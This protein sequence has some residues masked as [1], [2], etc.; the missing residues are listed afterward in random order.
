MS[1]VSFYARSTWMLRIGLLVMVVIAIGAAGSSLEGQRRG[2]QSERL[3]DYRAVINQVQVAL[4]EME[5]VQRGY[6]ITGEEPYLAPYEGERQALAAA[7]KDL[8]RFDDV[9]MRLTVQKQPIAGLIA[10]KV[11][12]LDQTVQLRRDFGPAPAVRL[13]E[14]DVGRRIMTVLHD[15]LNETRRQVDSLVAAQEARS[16][17]QAYVTVGLVSAGLLLSG[18]L[19][20]TSVGFLRQEIGA[21][22]KVEGALRER[23]AALARSNAELEQFAHVASHDL[24]EP[25]RMVSSYTQLLRLRYVGKLGADA[26]EFI[27][28]AVDGTKRMQALINDLLN[29]SRVGSGANP[30]E[31]VNLGVAL[32]DTLK[33]LEMRIKDCGAIVTHDPLPTV[34]ADPVQMRQLL[35][36]LIGN[37][38][39]F[40]SPERT[41]TVD[42]S[43][44]REGP[45]WLI[46]V[47]DNGIGIEGQYFKNV[48]QIFKRLHN[49]ESYPGT[50]IG[51]AVCQKIVERHG[52]RIWIESAFGQGS[53]FLFTLPAMETQS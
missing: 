18:V 24:Q 10:E 17:L 53:T 6:L 36:N 29:L 9:P 51:L 12:E 50:G 32:D 23:E 38:M 48:F 19:A 13:L 28:Y 34:R 8:G 46:R 5:S 27:A 43:A 40:R 20:A 25:L 30:M 3:R 49:T 2:H 45:E 15:E 16:T 7:M 14:T 41:S 21:R 26:D 31:P 39:K 42:V 37:G 35:L 22:E 11:A 33:D 44:A 4:L 47:R 52:G 1:R